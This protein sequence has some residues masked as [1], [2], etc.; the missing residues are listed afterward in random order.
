MGWGFWQTFLAVQTF[1]RVS[2]NRCC[3]N[4]EFCIIKTTSSVRTSP[5]T[6]PLGFDLA[7]IPTKQG[8]GHHSSMVH[9]TPLQSRFLTELPNHF[10]PSCH[11]ISFCGESIQLRP[12]RCLKKKCLMRFLVQRAGFI[13]NP[14]VCT[15]SGRIESST[16]V[17][18]SLCYDPSSAPSIT[19]LRN[20]TATWG[21]IRPCETG[22]CGPPGLQTDGSVLSQ[23]PTPE[24]GF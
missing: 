14:T 4:T 9:V 5:N 3:I 12:M 23:S 10:N 1:L 17:G 2:S 7:Y 8:K 11:L 22:A 20:K 6:S 19:L 24:E 15:L 21:K 16:T 13:N 18:D